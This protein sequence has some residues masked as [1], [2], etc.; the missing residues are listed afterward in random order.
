MKS[1]PNCEE[2]LGDSVNVCFKCNYDFNLKRII[3]KNEVNQR[4]I[5][6]ENQQIKAAVLAEERKLQRERQLEKNPQYEYKSVVIDDSTDGTINNS[7]LQNIL[8]EHAYKG[9]RLHSAFSNEVGK[10]S[11]SVFVG[12][13]GTTVNATID[14]TILIFERCIKS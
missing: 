2:L 12:F 9:W 13:L 5:I 7:L 11:N 6:A 8:D 10:C 14:Q 3:N 4:R 1:C